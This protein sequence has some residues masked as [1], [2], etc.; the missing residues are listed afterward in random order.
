MGWL[1]TDKDLDLILAGKLETSK[2]VLE[3]VQSTDTYETLEEYFD[4]T[5]NAGHISG[6]E[7]TDNL[8]GTITV[9]AGTGMIKTTA[10]DLG[11]MKFFD[12]DETADIAL[13]AE[14]VNYVYVD[15]NG[16]S[17]IVSVTTDITTVTR[18]TQFMIGA[19]FAHATYV[20]K[21]EG[22]QE[23][24]GF[25][26]KLFFHLVEDDG[27]HRASGLITSH[28]GTRNV[29]ITAGIAYWGLKR[30]N[31]SAFDSSGADTFDYLY[32]DTPSGW[33]EVT[34]QSQI[35]N[36]YYDDGSGTLAALTAN[37]Y[38][39]HWVYCLADGDMYV[40]YGQGDYTLAQ[41]EA[42]TVPS[43]LPGE[44]ADFGFL[45]AKI[46]I[47][48][49]ASSFTEIVI[50]WNATVGVSVPTDHGGLAGL[51]DDDHTQ[52]VRHNLSTASNDF[53]VGSGSNTWVKKTLAEVGAILE[54]DL[55]HGN[56]QGLGDD[57]HSQY[58]LIDGT[59]AMTGAL[60]M[61][62]QNIINVDYKILFTSSDSVAIGY[63]AGAGCLGQYNVFIGWETGLQAADFDSSVHIG[64][65][66]GRLSS[67]AES[68]SIGHTSGYR[69]TGSANTSVGH[70]CGSV[71]NGGAATGNVCLGWE[72]GYGLSTGNY[73]MLIGYRA[74]YKLTTGGTNVAIGATTLDALVDGSSNVAIGYGALGAQTGG[75][76]NVA[77]GLYAGK[78]CLTGQNNVFIGN[79]AGED[80]TASNKLYIANSN[81]ATPLIYGT[82]PNTLLV[83]QADSTIIGD[84]TQTPSSAALLITD[85]STCAVHI[86]SDFD[87]SAADNDCI[88]AFYTD[89]HPNSG[90]SL[91]GTYGYNQ[92]DD[93]MV[94]SYGSG[95]NRHFSINSA[96]HIGIGTATPTN[97]L[98]ITETSDCFIDLCADSDNNGAS[99]DA[100]VRFIID[101]EAD[102]G[103]LKGIVAYDGGDANVK[104][105]FG[106]LSNNNLCIDTNNQVSIGAASP[107]NASMTSGLN[108]Y[109]P[110]NDDEHF[111]IQNVDVT[112]PFTDS[113][114]AD[115]FFSIRK[116]N[117][118][119]GGATFRCFNSD[120]SGS[121]ATALEIQA[122]SDSFFT[123][124]AA[125]SKGAININ[126]A[127]SDGA[128]GTAN[129][130]DGSVLF[131]VGGKIGGSSTRVWMV[132]ENGASWQAGNA[133]VL[134]KA[135]IGDATTPSDELEVYHS[136]SPRILI[137]G[138]G[139]GCS[140]QVR[141]EDT[142]AGQEQEWTTGF[143]GSGRTFIIRD[144]T[145]GNKD[146]LTVE[147]GI[148][149]NCIYIDSAGEIGF[150]T[151]TPGA[152]LHIYKANAEIILQGTDANSDAILTLQNDAQEFNVQTD[153]DDGD[154]FKIYDKTNTKAPFK[155]EPGCATDTLYLD[156]DGKVGIGCNPGNLNSKGLHI[157]QLGTAGTP[158]PSTVSAP[159]V[160]QRS[161]VAGNPCYMSVISGNTANCGIMIGDT[162]DID[163][164]KI[165]Y[166]HNVNDLVFTVNTSEV[167]RM[168]SDGKVGINCDPTNLGTIG[169]HILAAGTAGT[170]VPQSTS[171]LVV[172]RSSAAGATC[173]ISVLSGN[174]GTCG[175]YFGD[176]DDADNGGIIYD[177]DALDM[178]F[179]I[180]GGISHCM[181]A[182]H[183]A[184]NSNSVQSY[185]G[186]GL[187]IQLA[188][189]ADGIYMHSDSSY[190]A[191]IVAN[192]NRTSAN[193]IVLRLSGVW[194][195][196]EVARIDFR[197]GDDDTNKDDGDISFWTGDSGSVTEWMR[198]HQSGSLNIGPSSYTK[199]VA[200][201]AGIQ[202]T[203]S[204]S[205]CGVHV[206][207]SG[208]IGTPA[209]GDE[210]QITLQDT[211]GSGG[212][213]LLSLLT[214]T[215]GYCGIKAGDT[216]SIDR[217]SWVYYHGGDYW[218]YQ[219][220]GTTSAYFYKQKWSLGGTKQNIGTIGL[221]I[222]QQANDDPVLAF[223]S[224]DVAHGNT[225]H[226]YDT[227]CYG[228][229]MK[230][231]PGDG[232][233][234]MRGFSD[235][236]TAVEVQ[237]FETT[238]DTTHTTAGTGAVRL[239]GFKIS[240]TTIGNVDD[241]ANVVAV[242]AYRGGAAD[243]VF[244]I[245]E[246]GNFWYDGTGT[247]YDEYNDAHLIRALDYAVS[248]GK[249]IQGK[250]D[251]YVQ[252]NEDH[253]VELGILGARVS[254]GGLVSGSQLQRLHNGAIWQLYEELQVAKD[255]IAHLEQKLLEG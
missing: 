198:L 197:A 166:D 6:G 160:V 72:T 62:T 223:T 219:A 124:L 109:N 74:G 87:N 162:D 71:I 241:G 60:D 146:A 210:A 147:P 242:K 126:V 139:A 236:S 104:L 121:S 128:G 187:E 183:L 235:A 55:D 204:Q 246:N 237:G 178:S 100:G 209:A 83:L 137:T 24:S 38:G 191:D 243:T 170:P 161:S 199:G 32:R 134:G 221:E 29:A 174:A 122:F 172:Q 169:L 222:N 105:T 28:T 155:I 215:S 252:Y 229:F 37:R 240:G 4:T 224:S 180:N 129:L 116:F 253:L 114:D 45:V 14:E 226:A 94:M 61:G 156:A 56:L 228:L 98:E 112:Q 133:L 185:L 5:G 91:K 65:G 186:S 69:F 96:G 130:P 142:Y 53:L 41:A 238:N 216:D 151:A 123:T 148:P 177:H 119:Y 36:T 167:F 248:G 171:P 99:E 12:W 214:D 233:I 249:W 175:I 173:F 64:Y 153:G 40:V 182:N 135:R 75:D 76:K 27:L 127:D 19:V 89:G 220:E 16:G 79:Q 106:A 9:A 158:D 111:A 51:S 11:E 101:G 10:S 52:Y 225:V 117:N 154:K 163:V 217:G 136:T 44:V 244:I 193:D 231:S 13:S 176:T 43:S 184:I 157:L 179:R 8:D 125:G 207:S 97:R 208:T 218:Y 86:V 118:S 58:L 49:G 188:G 3:Q 115:T 31:L 192:T 57:D 107:S 255:R 141:F 54:S 35:D 80:E 39:V 165:S 78:N 110:G 73:N 150:G 82:F 138:D 95:S 159:L 70:K 250:W 211:G 212:V 67:G 120:T 33:V 26:H 230:N 140:A 149:D 17:P 2:V 201:G 247:A 85:H 245:D 196:T 239:N 234:K 189:T 7:I 92:G 143:E 131:S 144:I 205:K 90:G 145:G 48:K 15:Y 206:V 66:A 1:L 203:W 23:L 113:G 213:A 200:I 81:T 103:T 88:V 47:Q 164:C 20:H 34:G 152:D 18:T 181:A 108:I 132:D 50:P 227:N 42:A 202:A 30:I 195:D 22:G 254:E 232:G 194:N 251:Q 25:V 63:N 77:I 21:F 59:R 102:A 68:V 190:R 93:A 46:I 168:D 84:D